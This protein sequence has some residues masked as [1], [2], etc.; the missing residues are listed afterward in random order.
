M[1][2]VG[3]AKAVT[4]YE[5]RWIAGIR[6]SDLV[7]SLGVPSFRQGGVFRGPQRMF[8]QMDEERAM[9]RQRWL[10]EHSS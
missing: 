5:D 1:H 2:V 9:R 8:N 10:N 4:S 7:K 6:A 3:K